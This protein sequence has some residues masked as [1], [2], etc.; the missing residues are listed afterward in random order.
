MILILS[1][2]RYSVLLLGYCQ[3]LVRSDAYIS[4]V[5]VGLMNWLIDR[6]HGYYSFGMSMEDTIVFTHIVLFLYPCFS[7]LS[8][9]C[10]CYTGNI[11][12]RAR[13]RETS[14]ARNETFPTDISLSQLQCFLQANWSISM[15]VF[16]N[17]IILV[18]ESI[19]YLSRSDRTN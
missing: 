3:Q 10:S 12:R 13:Y 15:I 14:R 11:V 4:F 8:S 9:S 18:L 1:S 17:I 2:Q 6:S 7:L 5:V 19:F 16:L